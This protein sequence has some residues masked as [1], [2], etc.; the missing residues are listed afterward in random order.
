MKTTLI[1]TLLIALLGSTPLPAQVKVYSARDLNIPSNLDPEKVKDAGNAALEE[2]LGSMLNQSDLPKKFAILPLERD[3]DSDYFSM[4]MRNY[5]TNLGRQNGYELYTRNDAQWNQIL[6]EIKW[7][8]QFGDTMDAETVQKF[9]RI[10]GVQ[11][12][13]M[14]RISSISTTEKGDPVV[15][16]TLQAFEVETGKQLWGNEAKGLVK[17]P[18]DPD[19]DAISLKMVPGGWVTVAAVGGGLVLLLLILKAVGKASRPR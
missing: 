3:V 5:F 11:G 17:V 16:V 8:D 2:L 6:E 9:G 13:L 7:G 4:Q 19:P 18:T 1:L 10:Q 12:L 14:G 15:R